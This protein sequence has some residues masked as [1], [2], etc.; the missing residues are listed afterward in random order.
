MVE[1]IIIVSILFIW[2]YF[3]LYHFYFDTLC[4]KRNG[5]IWENQHTTS[6]LM[7]Q[8]AD[9]Y[10]C[11]INNIKHNKEKVYLVDSWECKKTQVKYFEPMFYTQKVKNLLK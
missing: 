4:D 9:T 6:V 10:V 3:L 7:W 1:V 2:V 8:C 5:F 11:N